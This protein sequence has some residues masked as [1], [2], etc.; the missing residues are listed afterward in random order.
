MF[1]VRQLKEQSNNSVRRNLRYEVAFL[2]LLVTARALLS[3]FKFNPGQPRKPVGQPGGGRWTRPNEGGGGGLSQ[4]TF[5]DPSGSEPWDAFTNTYTGEGDL[6]AQLVAND[7]GSITTTEWDFSDVETWD[8][9]QTL[10]AEDQSVITTSTLSKDGSADIFFGRGADGR[11][12]LAANDGQ[13]ELTNADFLQDGSVAF[14]PS[15]G[16]LLKPLANNA[17]RIVGS[18]GAAGA[19]TFII[20]MTALSSPAGGDSYQPLSDDVRLTFRDNGEPP[21]VESRTG[22][23]PLDAVTGETW[24]QLPNVDVKPGPAGTLLIDGEQLKTAIGENRFNALGSLEGRG[25]S[26]ALQPSPVA[27][28]DVPPG[29]IF[30]DGARPG[31]LYAPQGS[32][33]DWAAPHAQAGNGEAPVLELQPPTMRGLSWSAGDERPLIGRLDIANV[34]QSCPRF[35]DVHQTAVEAD[36]MVRAANPGLSAR[37]LGRLIHK[38]I[39]N[40]IDKWPEINV[41]VWSEEGFFRGV[42]QKGAALP[43]GGSRIDVLEDSGR[44]TVCIYD[45]KTGDTEM[46]PKQMIQ[47][48]QEALL[49]RPNTKRVYIIPLYTKR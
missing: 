7:D 14:Q 23:S 4:Q 16:D 10:M 39:A 5:G 43:A 47:Y 49:F 3:A 2:R 1:A 22:P 44:N 35:S 25:V 9:R 28:S 18:G 20:G 21:V 30:A 19:G 6:A 38:E 36:A 8:V 24:K 46:T 40:E 32:V 33:I 31:S 15:E 27:L 45:P 26:V 42:L 37:E 29:S 11:I 13:L 41:G 48:W 34:D 12:V 17:A